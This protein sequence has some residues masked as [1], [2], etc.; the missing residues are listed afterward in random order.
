LL[1]S[2]GHFLQVNRLEI[3]TEI[4]PTVAMSE[5]II[6]ILVELLSALAFTTKEIK[7]GKLS[8]FVIGEG[9]YYLTKE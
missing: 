9:I 1:D 4:P 3:Y 8:E 6:M 2:I 7:K 5:T